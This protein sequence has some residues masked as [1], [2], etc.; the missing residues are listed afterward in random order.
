MQAITPSEAAGFAVGGLLLAAALA[1]PRVDN[2]IAR[3]QRRSLGLCEDCGGL[4]RKACGK[5]K[6]RGELRPQLAIF[7][8]GATGEKCREC[9]GRGYFPCTACSASQAPK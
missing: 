5:C 8:Q 4:K 3:S 7:D 6:G 2:Y 1:A 9:M